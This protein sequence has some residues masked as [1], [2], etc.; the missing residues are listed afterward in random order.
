MC[1]LIPL[2]F[3][4]PNIT[5][6]DGD[7]AALSSVL[8][9]GAYRVVDWTDGSMLIAVQDGVGPHNLSGVDLGFYPFM[10]EEVS[11]G[12]TKSWRA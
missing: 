8:A 3:G 9:P 5:T 2:F 12:E 7:H 6:Y 4:F 10:G 1:L 11:G